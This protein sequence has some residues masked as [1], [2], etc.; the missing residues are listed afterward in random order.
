MMYKQTVGKTHLLNFS[1]TEQD[2]PNSP[3]PRNAIEDGLWTACKIITERI[4]DDISLVTCKECLR[5]HNELK[6]NKML[7]IGDLVEITETD[8]RF[9]SVGDRAIIIDIDR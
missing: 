6:D 7:Q 4:T 9:F 1:D 3:H 8:Q 2:Y 5:I